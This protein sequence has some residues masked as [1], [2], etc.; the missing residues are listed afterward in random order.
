MV[1]WVRNPT[2][3]QVTVEVWVL[4]PAWW[5]GLKELALLH[6]LHRSKPSLGFNPWPRSLH[7]LYMSVL[8]PRCNYGFI[9]LFFKNS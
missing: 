2:A 5:S 8:W 3:A 4:S 1:Q 9:Y 6:L 7:M